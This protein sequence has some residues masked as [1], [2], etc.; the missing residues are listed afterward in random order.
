MWV[1]EAFYEYDDGDYTSIHIGSG[2]EL[3]MKDLFYAATSPLEGELEQK[4]DKLTFWVERN[5][6]RSLRGDNRGIVVYRDEVSADKI[7]E[8]LGYQV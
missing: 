8:F 5:D 6:N 4:R 7:K 2:E 1:V 3:E